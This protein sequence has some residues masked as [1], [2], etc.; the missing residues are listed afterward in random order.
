M[1]WSVVK[2]LARAER[3]PN[4]RTIFSRTQHGRSHQHQRHD[5]AMFSQTSYQDPALAWAQ[6]NPGLAQ[7]CLNPPPID[8]AHD[9]PWTESNTE[10][11]EAYLNWRGWEFPNKL[12]GEIE[13]G[14]CGKDREHANALVSHLLSAPLTMASQFDRL[15][16]FSGKLPVKETDTNANKSVSLSWCCVGARAEASIPAVYWKEF[17]AVGAASM[18]F[19]NGVKDDGSPLAETGVLGISLDFVGP[20]IP[21]KGLNQSIRIPDEA[22]GGA[23]P[24]ASLS[25]S[26]HHRGYFHEIP[27]TQTHNPP[28][29]HWDTY[30][31]FNPGFGHPNLRE[32]WE[33]TLN[34]L[35]DRER[36]SDR[37]TGPVLLLTAHSEK[38]ASRDTAI[39]RDFHGVTDF[40]YRENPFASRVAYEDPFEKQHF[41]RPNHYVATVNL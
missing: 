23:A 26:N 13:G 32:S 7:K 6:S 27:G 17:L 40:E 1:A 21:P 3:C 8:G 9:S 19:R 5:A 41:V 22:A 4:S 28:S 16:K 39:L 36:S 30:I 34:M 25:L 20:D 14:D 18:S 11:L 38:D 33:P 31:F 12:F 29:K 37:E 2:Q 35:F 15:A 10:S 24:I